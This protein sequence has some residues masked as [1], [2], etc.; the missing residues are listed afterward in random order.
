MSCKLN[1]ECLDHQSSFNEY[2]DLWC[3]EKDNV[4]DKIIA[5][6]FYILFIVTNV[7]F[8]IWL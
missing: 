3:I 5:Y 6:V 2:L 8:N 1:Q 4:E 7:C